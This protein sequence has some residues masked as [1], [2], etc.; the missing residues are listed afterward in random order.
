MPCD[1]SLGVPDAPIRHSNPPTV[2]DPGEEEEEEEET[3]EQEE[4]DGNPKGTKRRRSSAGIGGPH[5]VR[6][7]GDRL[8][9]AKEPAKLRVVS[10]G[11]PIGAGKTVAIKQLRTVTDSMRDV[12]TF[13]EDVAAWESS[14]RRFYR[15]PDDPSALVML[16]MQVLAHYQEVTTRLLD[17]QDRCQQDG[18]RRIAIV[19]RSPLEVSEVFVP[20]N[21]PDGSDERAAFSLLCRYMLDLPVWKDATYVCLALE[22][23]ACLARI[24]RRSRDSESAM[25][26][27]YVRKLHTA[28]EALSSRCLVIPSARPVQWIGGR[29]AELAGVGDQYGRLFPEWKELVD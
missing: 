5:P 21:M 18:I 3:E 19:E 12:T 16:Q 2:M 22:P 24:R 26:A 1:R 7:R 20:I 25:D 8:A 15:N 10:V 14:L 13:E 9:R 11:G 4:E 23:D 6:R 17:L 29:I 28:Y 27:E